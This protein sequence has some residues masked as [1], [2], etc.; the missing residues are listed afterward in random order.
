V[1]PSLLVAAA[2]TLGA[3]AP[4][5]RPAH[6]IVGT[7]L[8]LTCTKDG[9]TSEV[10]GDHCCTFTADGRRGDHTLRTPPTI[11][12]KYE[13]DEKAR[14]PA[15]TLTGEFDVGSPA[16]SFFFLFEIDGDTLTVC[17]GDDGLRP[18]SLT[19]EKGSGSHL[20]KLRR[21]KAKE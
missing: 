2:I 4:K 21:V 8:Y 9:K 7:W 1:Y 12:H 20:Y 3:P 10:Q 5:A 13:L 17:L 11:W 6:P 18:K 19:G 15:F 14:P 16:K